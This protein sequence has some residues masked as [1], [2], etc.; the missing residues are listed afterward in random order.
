MANRYT[1]AAHWMILPGVSQ[2]RVVAKAI[3]MAM[4]WHTNNKTGEFWGTYK[5][6][7]RE[8]H[9]SEISVKRHVPRLIDLG[10]ITVIGK[11]STRGYPSHLYRM[12]LEAIEAL[13]DTNIKEYPTDTVLEEEGYLSDT[14]KGITV[15]SKGITEIDQGYPSDTLNSSVTRQKTRKKNSYV[16]PS[17]SSNSYEADLTGEEKLDDGFP[18]DSTPATVG[19]IAPDSAA[20]PAQHVPRIPRHVEL[21]DPRECMDEWVAGYHPAVVRKVIDWHWNHSKNPFWRD[22]VNTRKYFEDSFH[23]MVKQMPAHLL[24]LAPKEADEAR[25][26]LAAAAKAIQTRTDEDEEWTPKAKLM[27]LLEE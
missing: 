2:D 21:F 22:G 16:R 23:T 8:A 5:T 27:E 4:A 24:K 18:K 14:S 15:S 1:D 20:P 19:S 25:A 10:L 17:D 12:N 13:T 6:L 7:A 3:L 11:K 26:H 9:C